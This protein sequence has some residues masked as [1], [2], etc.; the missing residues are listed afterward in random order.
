MSGHLREEE[1]IA[2][3]DGRSSGEQRARLDA[4]LGSCQACR[5]QLQELKTLWGVLEEWNGIEASPGFEAGLRAR[6][7]QEKE[8]RRPWLLLRPAYVA[9]LVAA[10]LVALGVTLWQPSPPE[11]QPV[12]VKPEAPVVATTPPVAQ[13]DLATLDNQVLLENY[14][15]LEEFD[16]LFEPLK[17]E[18]NK[19]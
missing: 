1:L 17:Q 11:P 9:G 10:L 16:I 13:E 5:S 7:E 8:R 15:L 4:H 6:L 19:L 2:Y 14:E 18:E 12:G 3:L